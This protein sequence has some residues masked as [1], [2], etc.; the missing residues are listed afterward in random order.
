MTFFNR[1][2]KTL[3][4]LAE[5]IMRGMALNKKINLFCD[6]HCLAEDATVTCYLLGC[7]KVAE[8]NFREWIIYFL[9]FIHDCEEDYSTN[10]AELFPLNQAQKNF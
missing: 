5:S 9:S 10:L 1:L 8:V 4:Y 7:C 3:D 6:N 2:L